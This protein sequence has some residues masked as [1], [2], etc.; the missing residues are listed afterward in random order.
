MAPSKIIIR[1]VQSSLSGDFALGMD[2]TLLFIV[3]G[4]ELFMEVGL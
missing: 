4:R 2:K 1:S 3:R